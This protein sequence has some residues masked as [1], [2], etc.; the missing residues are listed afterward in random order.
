MSKI[1]AWLN[2]PEFNRW[3]FKWSL[4]DWIRA[5]VAV[6]AIRLIQAIPF[7]NTALGFLLGV[8]AVVIVAVLFGVRQRSTEFQPLI[9]IESPAGGKVPL[10][11]IVRGFA[12]PSPALVQVLILAGKANDRRWF[13]QPDA[14]ISRYG[15][16]AKCRFGD[17]SA[18][19]TGW[20]FDFCAVIPENQN[21]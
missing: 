7:Q 3:Y 18:P 5:S 2:E 6:I 16:T 12:Y 8:L 13:P 20:D 11:K 15:W 9:V 19:V 14:E 1:G 4:F 17:A 10:F 21:Q